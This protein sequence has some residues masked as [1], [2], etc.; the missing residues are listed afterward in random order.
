MSKSHDIRFDTG[1]LEKIVYEPRWVFDNEEE[2]WGGYPAQ[3]CTR[4]WAN[5]VNYEIDYVDWR[6]RI[7]EWSRVPEDERRA[8]S[9]LSIT[10]TIVGARER[11]LRDAIPHLLDY[12]PEA[13]VLDVGV[14]LTAFIPPRAFAMGE[15]VFNVAATYWKGN[16]DNILNTMVH[17]VFHAG[18]SYWLGD[19]EDSSLQEKILRNIHSEGSATYAAYT[20]RHLFPAPDDKDLQM[21]EDPETV[22]D[23]LDQVNMILR[24]VAEKPG[25]EVEKMMWDMGVIGRAFYTVGARMCRVIEEELGRGELV[26]TFKSGPLAFTELYNEAAEPGLRINLRP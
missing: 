5:A 22:R 20:A 25:S 11:F 6:R 12:L 15:I 24:A 9:L 13:T 26:S 23:H 19:D 8:S 17:E 18:Y 14:Y 2:F 1:A 3:R 16:P 4:D 10:E 21:L 7:D